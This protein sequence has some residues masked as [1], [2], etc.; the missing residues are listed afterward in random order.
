MGVLGTEME[1]GNRGSG[2]RGKLPYVVEN[3]VGKQNPANTS[4]WSANSTKCRD[5]VVLL[6]N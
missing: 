3:S 6:V 4:G 5:F 2:D 1:S